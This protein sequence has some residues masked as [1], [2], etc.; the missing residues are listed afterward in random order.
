MLICP[1][2]LK[3]IYLNYSNSTGKYKTSVRNNHP[4]GQ[5]FS[6]LTS[7]S[8]SKELSLTYMIK[9]ELTTSFSPSSTKAWTM[10]SLMLE[11]TSRIIKSNLPPALTTKLCLRTVLPFTL[12]VMAELMKRYFSV[13]DFPV[14]T[15]EKLPK[16]IK[17]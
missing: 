13:E 3:Y 6:S 4:P 7:I 16:E 15:I 11:K 17:L 8:W 10:E 9:T 5:S 14:Q 12:Q 2:L 1:V